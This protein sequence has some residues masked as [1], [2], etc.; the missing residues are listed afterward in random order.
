[1]IKS[2]KFD[3]TEALLQNS[4]KLKMNFKLLVSAQCN[5]QIDFGFSSTFLYFYFKF[6]SSLI[7]G[8]GFSSILK[9]L[10]I[11]NLS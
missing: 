7:S 6:T 4:K 9:F 5:L 8:F 1:M 2:I 11:L 10:F 3:S